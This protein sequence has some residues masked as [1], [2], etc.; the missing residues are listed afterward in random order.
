MEARKKD[1]E[2][3]EEQKRQPVTDPKRKETPKG[4]EDAPR[5]PAPTRPAGEDDD[6]VRDWDSESPGSERDE[7]R[8]DT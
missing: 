7:D 4:H 1:M 5:G 3:K 8:D 2:R 6:S